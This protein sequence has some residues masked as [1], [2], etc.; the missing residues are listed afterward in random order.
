[1]PTSTAAKMMRAGVFRAVPRVSAR[2]SSSVASA[3]APWQQQDV[4]STLRT[5]SKPSTSPSA[6]P[7]FNLP[8]AEKVPT[9]ML[10]I[11]QVVHSSPV[12]V[13]ARERCPYSEIAVQ[14]IAEAG[15]KYKVIELGRNES[16]LRAELA[17]YVRAPGQATEGDNIASS[18][19]AAADTAALANGRAAGLPAVFIGGRYVGGMGSVCHL[20]RQGKLKPLIEAAT[21]K[22]EHH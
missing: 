14:I 15:S 8:A 6:V 19:E 7:A 3:T 9:K 2:C 11:E 12:V 17:S 18:P 10:A 5:P 22:S 4:V 13:L 16:E 21:E 1:M 20:D